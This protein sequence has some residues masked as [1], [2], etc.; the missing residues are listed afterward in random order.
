MRLKFLLKFSWILALL[1]ISGT[2]LLAQQRQITGKVV[3]QK[4]GL[5]VPGVTVGIRGK[6][7]NVLTNDKGDFSL[8]ADPAVDALV[9][10]YV[11]YVRQTIPLAGKTTLTVRF[12]EESQNLD[13]EAVVVIG[14]GTKKRSEIL[15]S[16]ATISGAEIQDIPA[17]NL[18]G[19]LRNRIAG[20]GVGQSSGRP[21]GPITLNIRNATVSETA[22]Q[23]GVSA[24]PLYI[25]DG[26]TVT[27][28]AFDNIDASMVENLSF[29]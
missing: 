6:T 9:F 29:L 28:E 17:P 18:A 21:G 11:G 12:A 13:N 16:V 3:D 2:S 19:A 1:A 27:R 14:Y 10:S 24:E 22:T 7:N 23:Y 20:V 8:V 5:P 4:D 25:V 26:I 15:G